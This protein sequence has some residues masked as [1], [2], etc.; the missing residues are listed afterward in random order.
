MINLK[1]VSE[2]LKSRRTELGMSLQDVSERTGLSPSTIM[3]YE[4]Q[5]IHKLPVDN[6][7]LLADALDVSVSELLGIDSED[8][9]GERKNL[10]VEES[11]L[12]DQ[13]HR[14]NAEGREKVIDY[15]SDIKVKYGKE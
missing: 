12:L 10:T 13:Y 6:L 11:N 5:S 4:S 2:R 7:I 14:L 8:G 3:R 15:I 9:N 1:Q